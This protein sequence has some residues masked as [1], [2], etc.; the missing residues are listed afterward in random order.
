MILAGVRS[1]API[2][3]LGELLS[4]K[5][6]ILTGGRQ[7]MSAHLRRNNS[8]TLGWS[9]QSSIEDHLAYAKL[10]LEDGRKFLDELWRAHAPP[11]TVDVPGI[12]PDKFY[13]GVPPPHEDDKIFVTTDERNETALEY[14]RNN[15]VVLMSDLLGPTER[16]L[17]GW[18]MLIGDIQAQVEQIIASHSGFFWGSRMS[19][20]AG[21]I[22]NMRAARGMDPRTAKID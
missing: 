3:L 1:I 7:F 19:G 5:M 22:A 14:L 9:P 13:D 12:I 17:V 10:R 2:R 8:T 20:V 18:P 6:Q 11:K 16:R 21:G 15:R 4:R